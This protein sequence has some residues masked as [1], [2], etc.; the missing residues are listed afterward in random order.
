MTAAD[1]DQL[2]PQVTVTRVG[3]SGPGG[4]RHVTAGLGLG[5]AMAAAANA[6]VRLADTVLNRLA[7][8]VPGD[9][10]LGPFLDRVPPAGQPVT[11][12]G[13][14]PRFEP[15]NLSFTDGLD[16]WDL[17]RGSR[18]E[19]DEDYSAG[20]DGQTAILSSAVPRPLGYAAL[21]QVIFA[22]DYRGAT[23]VFGGEVRTGPRTEQAGLRLEIRR[24]PWRAGPAHEDHG[25]TISGDRDWTRQEITALIP[26]DADM[27]RFGITLTG[28][29]RIA[30]R[31][32]ELRKAEP[33]PAEPLPAEP[34]PGD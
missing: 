24:H 29:G 14:R 7:V 32:P 28:P 22:D 21:V 27:I 17:D 26:E 34:A 13:Q 11:L 6:P 12:P 10:L 8:P 30:L 9:D 15:R 4:A 25:V 1:I 31:N 3:L 18:H 5:L 20:A 2:S 23:V 16:R 19:A 33:H